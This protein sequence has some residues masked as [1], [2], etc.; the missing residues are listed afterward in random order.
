M[1]RQYLSQTNENTTVAKS[2]I[3]SHL[4]KAHVFVIRLYRI[5]SKVAM[6]C[7]MK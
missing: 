5:V 3:F 6:P 7:E 1:I 2:K 4:N